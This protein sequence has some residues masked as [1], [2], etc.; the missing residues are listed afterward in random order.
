M[1]IP[2]LNEA[3]TVAKV[4]EAALADEPLEVLVID[5][6]STDATAS[7][8]A[9]AGATVLNWR[10]I[11][12]SEPIPGKGESLWRGVAAARGDIVVFVDADLTSFRPGM[13]KK[14]VAPFRND[15]IHLVKADY[16]RT[17]GDHTT[18]GGRVTELT[19]KPLLRLLFP[20]LSHIRQ[21]LGG[22]YAIRR[23]TALGLPF[24]AGYGVEVGLLIDVSRQFGTSSIAQ[25][26]LGS[27]SHNHQSLEALGS[28]ADIVAS[29]ILQRHGH[30]LPVVQREPLAIY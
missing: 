18:G 22:E 25:V 19:A 15:D 1:V 3:P 28:M 8:A 17:F 13:V 24:V 26:D 6:D 4:V 21:P 9:G 14:L 10:E 23:S 2:A 30:D 16:V 7:Q 27:R 11:I 12:D 29:T 5:A 20:E